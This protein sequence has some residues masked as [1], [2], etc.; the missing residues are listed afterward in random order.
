[1]KGKPHTPA[2]PP[3]LDPRVVLRGGLRAVVALRHIH[4]R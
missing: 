1:M 2:S 4:L 3:S